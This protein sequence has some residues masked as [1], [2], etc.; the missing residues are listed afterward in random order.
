MI[1]LGFEFV[2]VEDDPACR[3]MLKTII[4]EEGLGHVVAEYEQG[5]GA[6]L[7][8]RQNE[9][10]IAI[11]DLLLPGED[12]ISV[13]AQLKQADFSGRIVML[14]Q[15][16]NKEM[17]ARAYAAG[18]EYYINKPIN[19]VEVLAVLD[20][21]TEMIRLRSSLDKF[22]D[23][24]AKI[25]FTADDKKD[26]INEKE[27]ILIKTRNILSDLGVIGEAGSNDLIQ[28]VRF[29]TT[30]PDCES[31]LGNLKTLYLEIAVRY[32]RLNRSESGDPRAIE[33]RIRRAV[34]KAFENMSALGLEDYY[35]PKFERYASKF[36]DFNEVR[37]KM[38]ELK[39]QQ[40]GNAGKG[41]V[42][43]RQFLTALFNEVNYNVI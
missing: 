22:K 24:A 35:D 33:Q 9:A 34:K 43:I 15:V 3:L 41:R 8:V 32:Q 26:F 42:N 28:I 16:E 6:A 20:R 10:E 21:V 14:S 13:V 31:Y 4:E 5:V 19:R 36:F 23:L 27:T 2:L 17:I 25:D 7:A 39:G 29:L 30:V 40:D 37:R 11:I 12:G 18:V 1:N 38:N